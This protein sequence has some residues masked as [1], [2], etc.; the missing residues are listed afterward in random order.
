MNHKTIY[1]TNQKELVKEYLISHIGEHVTAFDIFASLKSDGYKIGLTTIYRHLESLVESGL[2]IKSYVSNNSS[3]CFEY[4]GN[5]DEH[6][7]EACYH[8]QC[9][10]CGKIIHLHC[11]EIDKLENHIFNDHHFKV[12]S[13]RMVFYGICEGCGNETNY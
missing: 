5:D 13:N 12:D 1:Q 10:N 6:S 2:V 9:V 11:D 4:I 8:C 3:A 7:K